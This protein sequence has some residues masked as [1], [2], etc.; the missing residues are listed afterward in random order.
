[1]LKCIIVINIIKILIINLL[2][3]MTHYYLTLVIIIF[4]R[5]QIYLHTNVTDKSN[6]L[7][8][9]NLNNIIVILYCH[10]FF[11]TIKH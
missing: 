3:V 8:I 10:F 6:L 5:I 4:Y 9:Y 2:L 1:M 11:K 7:I